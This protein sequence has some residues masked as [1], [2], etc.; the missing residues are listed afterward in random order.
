MS[1]CRLSCTSICRRFSTVPVLISGTVAFDKRFFRSASRDV[2]VLFFVKA[3]TITAPRDTPQLLSHDA[4]RIKLHYRFVRTA[5]VS[6]GTNW[7]FVRMPYHRRR[8]RKKVARSVDGQSASRPRLRRWEGGMGNTRFDFRDRGRIR[9]FEPLFVYA[10]NDFHTSVTTGAL[11]DLV[12]RW[13]RTR[14]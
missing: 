14:N 6:R 7:K 2:F 10:S 5:R 1:F 3:K 11:R 9:S 8:P 12:C 4:T 13:R